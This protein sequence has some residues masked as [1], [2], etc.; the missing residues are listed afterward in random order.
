MTLYAVLHGWLQ[1][2]W[3]VTLPN[4]RWGL[5]YGVI[6][7]NARAMGEFGAVSVISGAFLPGVLRRRESNNSLTVR[8]IQRWLVAVFYSFSSCC[9]RHLRLVAAAATASKQ[10]PSRHSKL[11]ASVGCCLL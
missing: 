8:H 5:L 10:Q 6:L 7:T 9:Q 1:V 2:F 11:T 4:I 3:H